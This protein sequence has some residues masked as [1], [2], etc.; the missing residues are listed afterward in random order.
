MKER[1]YLRYHARS[2]CSVY[3]YMCTGLT[4]EKSDYEVWLLNENAHAAPRFDR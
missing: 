2:A 1:R 3:C 4:T